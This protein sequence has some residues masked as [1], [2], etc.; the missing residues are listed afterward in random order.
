MNVYKTIDIIIS[1]GY[2]KMP[3]VGKKS[4]YCH[5]F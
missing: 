4:D 2:A 5:Q 3:V 1:T